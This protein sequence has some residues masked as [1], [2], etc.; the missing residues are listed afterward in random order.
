MDPASM[1]G[2]YRRLYIAIA[3]NAIGFISGLNDIR[4]RCRDAHL[5]IP[6]IRTQTEVLQLVA[7]RLQRWLDRRGASLDEE[8]RRIIGGSLQACRAMIEALNEKRITLL[9]WGAGRT[10]K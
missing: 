8:E 7:D 3:R 10:E 6:N 1:V 4:A 9:K 2:L 5:N